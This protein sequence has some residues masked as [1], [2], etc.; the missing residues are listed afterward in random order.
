MHSHLQCSGVLF[1]F[2]FFF[3]YLHQ[4]LLF[5]VFLIV[6]PVALITLLFCFLLTALPGCDVVTLQGHDILELRL[7]YI[8]FQPLLQKS[9]SPCL[10]AEMRAFLTIVCT[11]SLHS[12]YEM[13]SHLPVSLGCASQELTYPLAMMWLVLSTVGL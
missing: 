7:G 9:L 10:S 12:F 3:P 2:F 5:L 13:H 1:F 6:L 8:S 4:H 11:F